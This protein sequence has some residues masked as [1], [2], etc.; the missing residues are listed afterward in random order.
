MGLC[1]QRAMRHFQQQ[2]AFLFSEE[3]PRRNKRNRSLVR[4]IALQSGAAAKA[5]RANTL[6]TNTAKVLFI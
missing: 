4:S 5:L 2:R 6:S 1:T 3:T